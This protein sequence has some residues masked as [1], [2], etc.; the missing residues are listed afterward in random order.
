VLGA[1]HPRVLDEEG[2][3]YRLSLQ[4]RARELGL[5]DHVLFHSHFV[6]LDELLEYVGAADICV[7]PYSIKDHITSGALAYAVGMGKAV[8][9]TPYWYAEELLAEGRG[10]LVPVGDSQA[11]ATEIVALIRDRGAM[12][13]TRKKAYLYGRN[14]VW[15]RVAKVYLELFDEVRSH[16]SKT[17][18]TTSALRRP[19][20][21]T[22][23]PM[24][25]LDHLNRL[26][27]D[28]GPSHFARLSVPVWSHGYHL[29]DA[30]AVL[31]ASAKY[32]ELFDNP[33]AV[34]M[35]ETNLGLI[36]VL[37]Q[38]G[39]NIA[40]GLDYGRQRVGAAS[41]TAVGKALWS[42][43]FAVGFG[44]PHLSAAANDLF[45]MLLPQV[46]LTEARGV[47][48]A[49]L[50]AAHCLRRFPGASEV[51]RRMREYADKLI[52]CCDQPGW[53][54]YWNGADWPTAAEALTAAAGC[55]GEKT[56]R[57]RALRMIEELREQTSNGTIFFRTGLNPHEEELPTTAAAFIGALVTAFNHERDTELLEPIRAA[58]DWF[59]GDN[60]LGQ[61]L[62]DF[63]T[64]G[65]YDAL[66]A[67]G[68][69]LNLGTEATVYCLLAFLSV[70]Q[71]AGV[72]TTP[73]A[74]RTVDPDRE[75]PQPP[76]TSDSEET[77]HN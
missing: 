6:D 46:K 70:H 38:D 44:V 66:A 32:D 56:Y 4:R 20:S 67:S 68:L 50:G 33:G 8:V 37:V 43:G 53:I 77:V 58:V 59:L 52:V 14:M 55:L 71:L 27:D 41:E 18:L 28:T 3:A 45:Q 30:A 29:E 61:A 36:H 31:V 72:E 19:L 5:E 22:N 13:A 75:T 63:R 69:N 54:E 65:C 11:L 25:K 34:R 16:L 48:Y 47:G 51:R 10:R 60:R 1:T 26:S 9:S 39:G 2:E 21:A 42:L 17:V 12:G 62:Y 40:Q 74:Q 7:T 57:R 35:A 76:K 49:V 23:L 15:S 73:E 24:P 64:G